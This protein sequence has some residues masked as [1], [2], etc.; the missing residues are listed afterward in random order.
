LQ[1]FVDSDRGKPPHTASWQGTAVP[2][3]PPTAVPPKRVLRQDIVS[4]PGAKSNGHVVE[5]QGLDEA[6]AVIDV[7]QLL[8][9][10]GERGLIVEG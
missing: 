1:Q 9:E 8:F 2:P 6:Q 5:D 10:I 3:V 7:G 4:T